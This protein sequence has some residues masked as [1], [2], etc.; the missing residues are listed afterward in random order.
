MCRIVVTGLGVV[1]S[2]GVGGDEFWSGLLAGRSGV[3]DVTSFDTTDYKV[4]R[5]CEV[6]DFRPELFVRRLCHSEMGRS[7]QL[8][9]AA[10]R[11][12]LRDAALELPESDRSRWGVVVG[13]TTGEAQIIEKLNDRIV[14]NDLE[15]DGD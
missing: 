13:T 12:A 11:L 6:H 7:S 1:S 5:G 9:I 3:G 14:A 4:H 2:I 15:R 8:A 10:A